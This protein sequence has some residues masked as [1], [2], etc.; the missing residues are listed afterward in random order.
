MRELE[1]DGISPVFSVELSRQ[2]LDEVGGQI[3]TTELALPEDEND[4]AEDST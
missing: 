3:K 4:D 1:E 2:T